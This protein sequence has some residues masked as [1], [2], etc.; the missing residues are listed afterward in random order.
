MTHQYKRKSTVTSRSNYVVATQAKFLTTSVLHLEDYSILV[1]EN[2][3]PTKMT[4][5]QCQTTS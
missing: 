3:N 5:N 4:S 1:N 2:T